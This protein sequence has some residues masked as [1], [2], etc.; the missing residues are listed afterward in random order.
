MRR[1]LDC[2]PA[3]FHDFRRRIKPKASLFDRLWQLHD[4]RPL[5]AGL[6]RWV[7]HHPLH[8]ARVAQ[9]RRKYRADTRL[10]PGE[11]D[12]AGDVAVPDDRL[13]RVRYNPSAPTAAEVE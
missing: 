9:E 6:N 2:E 10:P 5:P 3:T 7:R 11:L 12:S 4:A 13:V 1:E 8:W